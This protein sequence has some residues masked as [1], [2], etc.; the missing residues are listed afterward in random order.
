LDLSESRFVHGLLR[1]NMK[2]MY[3]GRVGYLPDLSRRMTAAV[4]SVPVNVLS[5]VWRG[6]YI[7][8]MFLYPLLALTLN[9]IK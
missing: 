2:D 1:G 5:R 6:V 7:F 3:G 9:F 8:S 4:A